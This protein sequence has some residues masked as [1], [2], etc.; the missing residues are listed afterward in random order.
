MFEFKLFAGMVECWKS[1]MLRI[2]MKKSILNE[3]ECLKTIIPIF[4]HS[5]I[6]IGAKP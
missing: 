3:I 2:I 1:G 6:P 5:N 4:H